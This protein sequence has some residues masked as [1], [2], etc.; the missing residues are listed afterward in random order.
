MRRGEIWLADLPE[1]AGSAPYVRLAAT[2]KIGAWDIGLG[3]QSWAERAIA[4]QSYRILRQCL[5]WQPREWYT[6]EDVNVLQRFLRCHT[7]TLYFANIG[8]SSDQGP[9]VG[10]SDAG[11]SFSDSI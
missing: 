5:S 10:T 1:P 9:V 8:S 6:Y 2:P 11:K 3:I 7:Y 4:A